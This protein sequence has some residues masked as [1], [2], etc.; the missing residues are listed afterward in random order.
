MLIHWKT[1]FKGLNIK[2]VCNPSEKTSTAENCKVVVKQGLDAVCKVF[3][4]DVCKEFVAEDNIVN[5]INSSK[6]EKDEHELSLLG[7]LAAAKGIYLMGCNKS[8]SG[9]YCPLAQY[10]TTTAIDFG[11]KNFKTMEKI[12]E[13]R[14]G[15]DNRNEFEGV[16]N[17]G[18]D[19]LTLVPVLKDLNN[20]LVESC[21]DA[22]CNKNILALDKIVLTAKAAYEKNQKTDLTKKFPKV[23]EYYENYLSKYRNKECKLVGFPHGTDDSSDATTI[24]R[25]TYS[26]VT[27]MVASVL[28]LL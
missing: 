23:F 19:I 11:F 25:I 20:I 22:S 3:A 17:F 5:L 13:F 8:D 18:N 2:D 14:Y 21:S 24:K 27:M 28:L 7:K 9:K 6:C 4:E 15:R 12:G 10:A 1:F 16:L 26:L